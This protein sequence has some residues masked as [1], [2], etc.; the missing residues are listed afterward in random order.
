MS[1]SKAPIISVLGGGSWGTM[2]AQL[3]A[4]KGH[5]VRLWCR[6]AEQAKEINQKRTN[7]RYL[8]GFKLSSRI[9]ATANLRLAVENVPLIF[10]VIP[11]KSFRSVCQEMGNYLQPDQFVVH[12]T[13]GIEA[14]SYMRM[15]EILE[16]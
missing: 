9:L 15:S 7:N 12:G 13:K 2:V 3:I 16:E 11:A 1:K 14:G 5:R 10:V 6:R 8:E 4:T